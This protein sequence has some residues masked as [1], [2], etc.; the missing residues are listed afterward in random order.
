MRKLHVIQWAVSARE[1]L[2]VAMSFIMMTVRSV[3]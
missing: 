1:E 3:S 2:N